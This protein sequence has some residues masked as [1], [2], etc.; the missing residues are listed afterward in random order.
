M[1]RRILSGSS[2]EKLILNVQPQAAVSLT[3]SLQAF[4]GSK[5]FIHQRLPLTVAQGKPTNVNFDTCALFVVGTPLFIRQQEHFE[6]PILLF[7]D[8]D[9]HSLLFLLMTMRYSLSRTGSWGLT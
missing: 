1:L 7:S 4:S 8:M 2:V 6:A 9:E 5:C 3:L